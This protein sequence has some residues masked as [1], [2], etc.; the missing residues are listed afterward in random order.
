[1]DAQAISNATA[2]NRLAESLSPG[3]SAAERTGALVAIS[4]LE[5]KAPGETGD[6]TNKPVGVAGGRKW[7]P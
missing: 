5:S 1:M 6:E 4:S 3:A 2:K 7:K